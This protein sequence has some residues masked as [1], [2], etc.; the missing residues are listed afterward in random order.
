MTPFRRGDP[1]HVLPDSDPAV[2][3]DPDVALHKAAR[4]VLVADE[5]GERVVPMQHVI[6]DA[7]Q[8][9][10]RPFRGG[11][12]RNHTDGIYGREN[13]VHDFEEDERD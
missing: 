9:L 12:A 11:G 5:R 8:P 10:S 4:G 1:V 6:L 7:P 3:V 2:V 13:G